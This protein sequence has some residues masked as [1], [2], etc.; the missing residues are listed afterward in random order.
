[1]TDF[2]KYQALG[3]DYLV[4]DGQRLGLPPSS[5]AARVLCDR[6]FGIGADGVLFGPVGP[7]QAGRP[8]EVVT[9]NS[10]GSRCDRSV[11][12]VRMF[13]L[14]LTEDESLGDDLV[15]RTP[16][17]DSPVRIEASA[18]L[19]TVELDPP[20]FAVE[21]IPVTGRSG[22]AVELQLEVAA[23]RLNI[24]CLHNGNPHAVLFTDVLTAERARELGPLIA[25][26]QD[27]PQRVNV[28]FA[29]VSD[30]ATIDLLIYERGA[31]YTLASGSSSCAA[32]SAARRLGLVDELVTVRM[33]GG[34][35]RI[36]FDAQLRVSLTGVVEKVASGQFADPLRRRLDLPLLT[37]RVPA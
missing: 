14:Q 4:V 26:H 31:G 7:V 8:V 15:I 28:A 23:E 30:R 20:S 11:N 27:F 9:Y 12:G 6:H 1:M 17:G 10:D 24:T 21:D 37:E 25:S 2:V 13:A 33:P 19:V 32:A 35:V 29:R 3:N 34:E 5:A 36:G 16:A 18:G 22:S